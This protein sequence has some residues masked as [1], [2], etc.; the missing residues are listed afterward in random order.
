MMAP[1]PRACDAI[2]TN[3]N[4]GIRIHSHL[5]KKAHATNLKE[6]IYPKDP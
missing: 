2:N 6:I 1:W 3:K 4:N 5:K